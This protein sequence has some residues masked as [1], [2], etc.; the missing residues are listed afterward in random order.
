MWTVAQA[1]RPFGPDTWYIPVEFK[2]ILF[3]LP[4]CP[5]VFVEQGSG[6][7][8][9]IQKRVRNNPHLRM[10]GSRWSKAGRFRV[11]LKG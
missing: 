10:T 3:F 4:S 7:T 8:K 2:K 6:G 11:G 1:L 9:M 5:I